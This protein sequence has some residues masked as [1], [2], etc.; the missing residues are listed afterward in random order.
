MGALDEAAA[1]YVGDV[2]AVAVYAG[3][4]LIWSAEEDT[5]L[6]VTFYLQEGAE[7]FEPWI[8]LVA[9]A[10]G[11]ANWYDS[12]ENLIATGLTPTITVPE[13][14]E[15]T[16]RVEVGGNLAMAQVRIINLGFDHTQD[17]GP[18][19][20]DEMYDH[21]PQPVVGVS[22]LTDLT[23]LVYFMAADTP[24]TG[25][26]NF[27]GLPNILAVE[28]FGANVEDVLFEGTQINRLCLEGNRITSLDL[29]PV[30]S[31][32]R[33][34]R[35]AV[36]QV[37]PVEFFCDDE[38]P[39]LWHYCVRDQIVTHH[40]ETSKMPAVEQFW[41]WDTGTIEVEPPVSDQ[42]NSIQMHLNPFSPETIDAWLIALDNLGVEGGLFQANGSNPP[43][44]ASAT[45]RANLVSKSWSLTGIPDNAD[46]VWE[47]DEPT[48]EDWDSGDITAIG[49]TTPSVNAGVLSFSSNSYVRVIH[50]PDSRAAG[51][52]Y[53]EIEVDR[54][55]VDGTAGTDF[56]AMFSNVGSDGN[57]G[58]RAMIR[59]PQITDWD[60]TGVT[61]G[62]SNGASSSNVIPKRV[63]K[64]PAGWEDAGPH[65]IGLL[66]V[67]DQA[68][69]FFDGVEVYRAV[70][71]NFAGYTGGGY[72]GVGGDSD[73]VARVIDSWGLIDL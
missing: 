57:G 44:M 67:G 50:N 4:E 40:I 48:P 54:E 56:F 55:M 64:L 22:E 58:L 72:V 43:T 21:E 37:D 35:C 1:V 9:E 6:P 68:S 36:G 53:F 26:L 28:C 29:T 7:T 27:T 51:D 61:F 13:D 38:L 42:L 3:S 63:H 32:I 11:T 8:E 62:S 17:P 10:T 24:L 34:L 30:A 23:G 60:S 25:T 46:P 45:A 16:L 66:H 19:T 12:E 65:T 5:G 33:D 15:V 2:A 47:Y 18:E 31:S 73:N 41:A 69:L 49:S 20:P 59:F 70:S 14:R 71:S 52:C 39:N